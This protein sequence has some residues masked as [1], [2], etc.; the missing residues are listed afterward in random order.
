MEP[1]PNVFE[2]GVLAAHLVNVDV[3]EERGS[4]ALGERLERRRDHFT[5]TAPNRTKIDGYEQIMSK[6]HRW[7]G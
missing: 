2:V 4:V 6:T 1:V 5:R 7:R 3:D